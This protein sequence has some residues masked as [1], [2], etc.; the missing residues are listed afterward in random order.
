MGTTVV[1]HPITADDMARWALLTPGRPS[2]RRKLIQVYLRDIIGTLARTRGVVPNAIPSDKA[3]GVF[4]W[5][6]TA[7]LW[8]L[9]AVRERRRWVIWNQRRVLILRLVSRSPGPLGS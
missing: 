2:E 4:W 3:P 5:Q 8:V 9:Y 7:D 1:L 6:Y